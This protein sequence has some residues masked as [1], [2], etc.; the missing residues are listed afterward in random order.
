MAKIKDYSLI[1][2]LPNHPYIMVNKG[3][4]AYRF[5][6]VPASDDW[7]KRC[8]GCFFEHRLDCVKERLGEEFFAQRAIYD[9]VK[10]NVIFVRSGRG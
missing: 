5:R 9:C 7:N 8:K 4:M 6:A 2:A 10:H 1:E 3:S